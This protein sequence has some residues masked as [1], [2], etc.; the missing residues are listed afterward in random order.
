VT[1]RGRRVEVTDS[2]FCL[3]ETLLRSRN[4][5][6]TR[7]ELEEALHGS[8]DASQSNSIEVHIHHL[9]RKFSRDLIQT[10]RGAGYCLNHER[11]SS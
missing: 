4:R 11:I 1:W 5:V 9:R 10:I 6:L 2:E 7:R 8:D 3:L